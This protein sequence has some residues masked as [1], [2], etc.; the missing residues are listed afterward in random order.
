MKDTLAHGHTTLAWPALLPAWRDQATEETSGQMWTA[1][2]VWARAPW[3]RLLAAPWRAAG[4]QATSSFWPLLSVWVWGSRPSLH[5][6]PQSVFGTSPHPPLTVAFCLLG[7]T[8]IRRWCVRVTNLLPAGQLSQDSLTRRAEKADTRGSAGRPVP[9][10][11]WAA[12]PSCSPSRVGSRPKSV[13]PGFR[14]QCCHSMVLGTLLHL[15]RPQF[16]HIYNGAIHPA[17]P[18]R[19][20]AGIR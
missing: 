10:Q 12:G 7:D 9:W 20:V 19:V 15:F 13:R 3:E 11:Q 1:G 2:D 4:V 5:R 6:H 17:C 14:S 16:C 18:H 8:R